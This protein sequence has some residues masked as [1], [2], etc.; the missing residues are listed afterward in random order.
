LWIEERRWPIHK[1]HEP[2]RVV[3]Q[4]TSETDCDTAMTSYA[5]SLQ[6]PTM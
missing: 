1:G 2:A 3:Q 5:A 4:N 6:H